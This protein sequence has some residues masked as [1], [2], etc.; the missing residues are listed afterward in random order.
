MNIERTPGEMLAQLLTLQMLGIF[1]GY[2][3]L[4]SNIN[5]CQNSDIDICTEKKN[6]TV[7]SAL[8]K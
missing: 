8:K 4:N 7:F 3:R 6:N 5:T 1:D 2:Q